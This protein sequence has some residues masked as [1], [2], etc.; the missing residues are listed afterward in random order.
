[1]ASSPVNLPPGF[2]LRT[3]PQASTANLP[4]GFVL[5]QQSSE[6][7]EREMQP[8]T[9][10]LNWVGEKTG[11]WDKADEKTDPRSFKAKVHSY[12]NA[13]TEG[14]A[15]IGEGGHQLV[16]GIKDMAKEV[17]RP[18]ESFGEAVM[19]TPV[20]V[21][22]PM[23]QG[24]AGGI[25]QAPELPGLIEQV[26]QMDDAGLRHLDILGKSAGNAAGQIGMGEITG[27]VMPRVYSTVSKPKQLVDKFRAPARNVKATSQQ[28][29]TTKAATAAEVEAAR[30][31]AT[32]STETAKKSAVDLVAK[33]DKSFSSSKVA[34]VKAIENTMKTAVE[35]LPTR[36][37]E[38]VVTNLREVAKR[39]GLPDLKATNVRDAVPE[40]GSHLE[41]R[42]KASY[43]SVDNA[44][45][46]QFQPLLDEIVEVRQ[47]ISANKVLDPAKAKALTKELAD[48]NR[49]KAA[50]IQQAEAAGVKGADNLIK[51]ADRDWARF[52]ALE[53]VHKKFKSASGAVR[54]GGEPN[55]G[56]FAT[57]VDELNN[58]GVLQFAL[59]EEQAAK[60]VK[61]TS[62]HLSK[63]Q[64]AKL[65]RAA[66]TKAES[67]M[68]KAG[69]AR[70]S[71]AR[72]ATRD[73]DTAARDA[74]RSVEKAQR[75]AEKKVQE[76]DKAHE[77]AK[78]RLSNRNKKLVKVGAAVLGGG[79]ALRK[80]SEVK[81]ALFG[82]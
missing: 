20:R 71:A 14:L 18:A 66:A 64:Q 36:L 59:G 45:G 69:T 37:R 16:T 73:V 44:L 24:M 4:P 79:Y 76:A 75:E 50:A 19:P 7:P 25:D 8:G 32:A 57:V 10:L 40:L 47:A 31:A 82:E 29:A 34:H 13:T 48:L 58:S 55:T 21:L 42:A 56:R 12:A 63:T 43:Q 41:A 39:D 68:N 78:E 35:S 23:I 77:A 11:M 46:G 49:R 17:L 54:H 38:N 80:G 51:V 6:A 22:R 26:N 60:L 67:E 70:E 74:E 65:A 30:N 28:L 33:A 3:Q 61:S 1:V 15:N 62:E 2:V 5:R 52:K 72:D 53:K 81:N 27:A 9:R